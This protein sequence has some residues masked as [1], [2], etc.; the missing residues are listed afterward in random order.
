MEPRLRQELDHWLTTP[1]EDLTTEDEN[2]TIEEGQ[3]EESSIG[4][5]QGDDG[6]WPSSETSSGSISR[7]SEEIRKEEEAL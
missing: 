1:P 6:I 7:D 3:I 4:E 5:H 2:V